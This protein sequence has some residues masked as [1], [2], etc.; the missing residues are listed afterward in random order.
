MKS[1]HTLL[2]DSKGKI[3][4]EI[5]SELITGFWFWQKCI[6]FLKIPLESRFKWGG[7]LFACLFFKWIATSVTIK[8]YFPN[9]VSTSLICHVQAKLWL[10]R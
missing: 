5:V 4:Q 8:N 7:C 10:D 9:P 6:Q 3:L 2:Y 1:F